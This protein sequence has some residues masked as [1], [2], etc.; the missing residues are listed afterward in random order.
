MILFIAG[1]KTKEIMVWKK[2]E[3]APV[4]LKTSEAG[5]FLYSVSNG[6]FFNTWVCLNLN[7]FGPHGVLFGFKLFSFRP[8]EESACLLHPDRRP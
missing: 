8:S 6:G 2:H 4:S 5:A 7:L 3:I 1:P